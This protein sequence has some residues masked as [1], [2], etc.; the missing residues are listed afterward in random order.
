MLL[1]TVSNSIR[2]YNLE[3]SKLTKYRDVPNIFVVYFEG[4]LVVKLIIR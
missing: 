3:N 1:P 2:D 4:K